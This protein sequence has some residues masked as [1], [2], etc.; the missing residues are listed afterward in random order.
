MVAAISVVQLP[1]GLDPV[2]CSLFGCGVTTGYG[3][4]FNTAKFEAGSTAAVFGLGAVG[5]AVIMGLKDAGAKRVIAV[6]TNPKKLDKAR[7]LC[8]Y[9][10]FV[11]PAD[12][13]GQ[14][15][16]DVIISMTT[17]EGFGGVDYSFECV[18]E[19]AQPLA[20]AC[21]GRMRAGCFVGG[22]AS[23]RCAAAR[24]ASC[25][26]PSFVTCPLPHTPHCLIV[27]PAGNT[28]L[29][30]S[31]LECT[32]RAWG[33]SIIIGVAAA[34]K[35]ISTRPFFLVV[36]RTWTGT[37]FGGVKGRSELPGLVDKLMPHAGTF[38]THTFAG[39]GAIND[40]F[41]VMHEPAELC[42][43]PVITL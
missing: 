22:P 37:A 25:V 38:V 16:E 27:P 11:N 34:G 17:E 29:M 31:A 39:I 32:H 14:K 26:T 5:L 6:D 21:R 12:H 36:G 23:F 10:E 2:K 41:H 30:R 20:A 1:E 8:P 18:G 43:R 42:I 35:E 9:V 7:E 19:S 28:T 3:A 24:S 33:K 15:I 4:V 13:A 40:A